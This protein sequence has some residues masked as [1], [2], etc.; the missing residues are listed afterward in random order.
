MDNKTLSQMEKLQM[1]ELMKTQALCLKKAKMYANQAQDTEI[2]QVLEILTSRD[3][4]HIYN[5]SLVMQ[6]NGI[7][8]DELIQ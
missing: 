7:S 6:E 4:G 8:T 2:K 3:E 1:Q 5:L